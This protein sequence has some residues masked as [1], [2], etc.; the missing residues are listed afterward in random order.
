MEE[1]D[2]AAGLSGKCVE[3]SVRIEDSLIRRRTS[4]LHAVRRPDLQIRGRR[5]KTWVPRIKILRGNPVGLTDTVASVTSMRF[6]PFD[7]T[8]SEGERSGCEV[9]QICC[10]AIV[11]M[12]W[13][14]TF[15][16]RTRRGTSDREGDCIDGESR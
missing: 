5:V 12:R 8:F 3:V 13:K 11:S 7:T 15:V 10:S 14:S 9:A 2:L 16:G 6:G 4:T 1:G